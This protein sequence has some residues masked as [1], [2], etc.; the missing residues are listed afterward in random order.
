MSVICCNPECQMEWTGE[1]L[2]IGHN[3]SPLWDGRCCSLCNKL[4]IKARTYRG[5][6]KER[7]I[8]MLDALQITNFGMCMT[9]INQARIL[10][11]TEKKVEVAKGCIK[12]LG[13]DMKQDREMIEEIK[14]EECVAPM[15]DRIMADASKDVETQRLKYEAEK[16]AGIEYRMETAQYHRTMCMAACAIVRE[17]VDD[18][19][20]DWSNYEG[21]NRDNPYYLNIYNQPRRCYDLADLELTA[22]DLLQDQEVLTRYIVCELKYQCGRRRRTTGRE[23]D[24]GTAVCGNSVDTGSIGEGTCPYVHMKIT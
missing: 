13:E 4:V 8:E 12:K 21:D 16:A 10:K 22:G 2:D 14:K 11:E 15:I 6:S 3:G 17:S 20:I 23:I 1:G 24:V 19:W 5:V 9:G 7:L 18:D